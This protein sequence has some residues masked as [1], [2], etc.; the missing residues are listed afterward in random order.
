MDA[1]KE[2]SSTQSEGRS[3]DKKDR[4][5]AQND[6]QEETKEGFVSDVRCVFDC[7]M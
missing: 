1:K 5:S 4:D 3:E 2:F 7:K 6:S